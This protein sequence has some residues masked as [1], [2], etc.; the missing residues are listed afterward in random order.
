VQ[1]MGVTKKL[2]QKALCHSKRKLG[3]AK[4]EGVDEEDEGEGMADV[5][6]RNQIHSRDLVDR[7]FA[8][9]EVVFQMKEAKLLDFKAVLLVGH[10]FTLHLPIF[11]FATALSTRSKCY[12]YLDIS[13]IHCLSLIIEGFI[14]P[15]SNQKGLGLS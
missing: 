15:K 2:K 5:V 1:I 9:N 6:A 11:F 14:G 12:L 3:G 10:G 8:C 13:H 4:A 7:L